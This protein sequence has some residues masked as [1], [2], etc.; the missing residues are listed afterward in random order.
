MSFLWFCI[1]ISCFFFPQLI[2]LLILGFILYMMADTFGVLVILCPMLV[3][4]TWYISGMIF[5]P[6]IAKAKKQAREKWDEYEAIKLY[7]DDPEEFHEQLKKTQ[8]KMSAAT[9]A[10]VRRIQKQLKEQRA[11]RVANTLPIAKDFLS[12]HKKH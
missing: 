9:L 3:L 5:D 8:P 2:L 11:K 7:C 1:I 12:K 10:R 4:V 6:K